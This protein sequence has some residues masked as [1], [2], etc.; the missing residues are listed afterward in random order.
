LTLSIRI[1]SIIPKEPFMKMSSS[2]L[3]AV[4]V[5]VLG[6]AAHAQDAAETGPCKDKREAKHVAHLEVHQCITAWAKDS[7][8]KDADPTD[9]CSAKMASYVAAARELKSCRADVKPHKPKK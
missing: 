4:V 2:L 5:V 7:G 6:G 1:G 9:D 8:P 3:S